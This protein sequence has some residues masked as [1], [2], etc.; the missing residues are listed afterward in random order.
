M[1]VVLDLIHVRVTK[2]GKGI[3]VKNVCVML[4]IKLLVKEL[5]RRFFYLISAICYPPCENGT[6]SAPDYCTCNRGWEGALCDEGENSPH[7]KYTAIIND[8]YPLAICDPPCLNGGQCDGPNRCKCTAEYTGT[9]CEDGMTCRFL[10]GYV[11]AEYCHD[12]VAFCFWHTAI[13][14]PPSGCQNGG[15]CVRPSLCACQA[16]WTG[17]ICDDRMHYYLLIHLCT[18]PLHNIIIMLLVSI[19]T[20]PQPSVTQVVS[21]ETVLVQGIVFVTLDGQDHAAVMVLTVSSA[22]LWLALYSYKSHCMGNLFHW[23]QQSAFLRVD[24]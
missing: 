10:W 8:Y 17:H 19:Y 15:V 12:I 18:L 13:C 7:T 20:S 22:N 1:E 5:F 16:Y 11:P 14:F 24:V 9:Q 21:M 4:H 6:C 3:I 2:D 23:L